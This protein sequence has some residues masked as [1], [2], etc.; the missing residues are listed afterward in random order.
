[1]SSVYIGVTAL[2]SAGIATLGATSGKTA[3]LVSAGLAVA[4]LCLAIFGK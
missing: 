2:L 4:A 1:M 3:G